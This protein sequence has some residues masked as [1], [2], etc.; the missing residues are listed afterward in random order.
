MVFVLLMFLLKFSLIGIYT[1]INLFKRSTSHKLKD[2]LQNIGCKIYL[3]ETT[4]LEKPTII[5]IIIIINQRINGC[6]YHHS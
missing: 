2:Q 4:K 6:L 1:I 3:N 5:I